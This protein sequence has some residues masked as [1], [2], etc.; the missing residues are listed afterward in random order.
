M[1]F[2]LFLLLFPF[3]VLFIFCLVFL[4]PHRLIPSLRALLLPRLLLFNIHIFF[5]EAS[6]P[7]GNEAEIFIIAILAE[8][9]ISE[10]TNFLSF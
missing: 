5:P 1:F 9:G 10:E 4:C 2:L 6:I 3:L 7:W 8:I